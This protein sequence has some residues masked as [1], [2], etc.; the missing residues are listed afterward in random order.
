M[1]I[2][3]SQNGNRAIVIYDVDPDDT[4]FYTR[5]LIDD[6]D[7]ETLGDA[8]KWQDD[9]N[10]IHRDSLAGWRHERDFADLEGD[11]PP[12]KPTRRITTPISSA[13]QS[14]LS[15]ETTRASWGDNPPDAHHI[16]R[17]LRRYERRAA[18]D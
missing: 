8:S 18:Q 13:P 7:D 9:E 17:I 12:P 14:S 15:K 1:S 5:R 11:P 16:S 3:T 2:Y 10:D 6:T 4:S